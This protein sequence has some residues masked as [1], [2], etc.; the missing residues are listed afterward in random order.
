ME[1]REGYRYRRIP[2]SEVPAK[3]MDADEAMIPSDSSMRQ[4]VTQTDVAR[5]AGV[6]N[7]T[8]SLSLRNC[9]SIPES[10]RKRIRAIADK[11]GYV[12]DPTLQALVAYRKGRTSSRPKETFAY[13]TNW[14]SCWGWRALPAHERAFLGAQRKAA[15]LGYQLE[16]FWL[17][18]PGM[19]QRRMSSMLYHR[20]I[21]GVLVAAH[22]ETCD[23]LSEI[24][25]SRLSAVKIGCFPHGPA[26]H[27]VIDDHNG[28]VRLAIRRIR[29]LGFERIGLV[30]EQGWDDFSDRAWSTGFIIERG[31]MP[32]SQ[33]IPIFKF[34]RGTRDWMARQ[35]AQQGS[36]ELAALA[37][38]QR[39]YRPEVI[40]GYSPAVLGKLDQLGMVVP[41]DVAYV[42][43]CLDRVDYEVAGVR[44]N[45]E[46]SG[47][48]A[49]SMLVGQLQRNLCGLPAVG[50]TTMVAGTWIE[51]ASL[52]ISVS[53]K[54]PGSSVAPFG[55]AA[56]LAS[57]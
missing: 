48:V 28:M 40:V 7:T 11:L 52:G 39:D 44:Q 23:E 30:M 26:L 55:E 47:E 12:P 45:G 1:L 17:G 37:K 19:N 9:P 50:T 6:H 33:R 35:T 8:V 14:S 31:N 36:G 57:A 4:R 53:A 32:S 13:I 20:G 18:E 24:D 51:G 41:K 2:K 38:W 25:W 27:R 5:V 15:E 16:H 34:T 29:A 3:L 56:L 49:V 54:G 42:D 46:I 10:T 22:R 43:L 21:T